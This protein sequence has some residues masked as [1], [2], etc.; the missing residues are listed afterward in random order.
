MPTLSPARPYIGVRAQPQSLARPPLIV[1]CANRLARRQATQ[2]FAGSHRETRMAPMGSDLSQRG[3]DESALA[4]ARMRQDEPPGGGLPAIIIEEIEVERTGGVRRAAL[5]F[6]TRLNR[7]ERGKE[8]L[9]GQPALDLG[10]RVDV[11]GLIRDG[12]GL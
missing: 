11:P 1:D 5:T 12:H 3:E 10:N 8:R 9:R 4:E 6:E 7:Q 2:Q